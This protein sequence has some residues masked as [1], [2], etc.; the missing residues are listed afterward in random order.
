MELS[1]FIYSGL[2]YPYRERIGR[3][4]LAS[5]VFEKLMRI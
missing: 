2:F 1:F 5:M 3:V 4:E